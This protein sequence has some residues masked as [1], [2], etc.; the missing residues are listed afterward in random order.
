MN[1]VI[2]FVD[3]VC[4]CGEEKVIS[5]DVCVSLCC[6]GGMVGLLVLFKIGSCNC[7]IKDE[8]FRSALWGLNHPGWC[9]LKSPQIIRFGSSAR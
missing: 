5:G 3:L 9:P 1:E 7:S 2:L 4:S 6:V 8:P